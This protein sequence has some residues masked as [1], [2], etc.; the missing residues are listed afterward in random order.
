VSPI[1]DIARRRAEI[2]PDRIALVERAT[3]RSLT[4]REFDRRAERAARLLLARGLVR[5][6]R[7]AILTL[8]C[9]A[10]FEILLG[11]AKAGLILVPLNWRLSA[12]EL[13]AILADCTPRL[14]VHDAANADTAAML[15]RSGGPPALSIAA[16]ERECVAPAD[17]LGDGAWPVDGLWYLLYTS[18]TTGR[19]KAV[20]QSFGMA[21]ANYVNIA[22]AIDLTSADRALNMLP[23]FHTAGI[24]L[25]TLPM[26]IAGGRTTI[27]PKF[28]PE[29]TL[30]AIAAGEV[31]CFFGVPAIYQALAAHRDFAQA[32]LSAVRSWGCGGAPL[33]VPLLRR[34]L[35]RGIRVCNGYGMTETGPTVFL[36]DPEHV[37]AKPGSVGKAQILSQIRIVDS[38]GQDVPAGIAGEVWIRGQNVTP[39]YW[40]DP[41]ATRAAFAEGGWLRTGDVGRRDEDGYAYL[42]DR[43]KDMYISG[44]ENVYPA[45]IEHVLLDHPDVL[46]A[47]VIGAPDE[48]WG[49]VGRAFVVGRPGVAPSAEALRAHCRERLAAYKVPKSIALVAEL[50]RTAAGKVQKHLL[51][52]RS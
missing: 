22:Q 41:Q 17:P 34:F 36:M 31:T 50:P 10:F 40:N 24:N 14:L 1:F 33:P 4:Y 51:K 18:G 44:G 25:Y 42:V 45:E 13:A 29:Q 15:E 26:L 48:R 28:D 52:A 7:V 49:E 2:A 8:N 6:D 20:M 3:G 43:I 21:L 37:E 46:E 35:S 23:L 11:C 19:P 30:A 12:G 16:Y 47:A 32:D 9:A 27:M 38:D 5:G 39:G